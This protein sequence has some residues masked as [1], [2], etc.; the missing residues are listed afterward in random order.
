MTMTGDVV[1]P[2]GR[3]SLGARGYLG[4]ALL[5]GAFFLV[6]GW[7]GAVAGEALGA[8]GLL[9]RLAGTLGVPLSM[10]VA[11]GVVEV[12]RGLASLLG[13]VTHLFRRDAPRPPVDRRRSFVLF[14]V[15]TPAATAT[16]GAVVGA[17]GTA[18]VA[19]WIVAAGFAAVGAA[20]GAALFF[21]ARRGF[22]GP[23]M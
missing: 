21:A 16:A 13:L 6:G 4:Y 7:A 8:E 10:A 11:V 15:V 5:L 2:D 1:V 22:F 14:L 18:G 19:V 3:E 9:A 17:G 20:A 23:L 12:A